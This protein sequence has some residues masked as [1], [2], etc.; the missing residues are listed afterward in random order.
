MHQY[1]GWDDAKKQCYD[2]LWAGLIDS[3]DDYLP[4]GIQRQVK[5]RIQYPIWDQVSE[6]VK[7]HVLD[8]CWELEL[9]VDN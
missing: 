4:I 6:M 5:E 9:D 3:V 7:L 8:G 2:I 1:T